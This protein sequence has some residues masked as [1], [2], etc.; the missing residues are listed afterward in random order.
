MRVAGGS[1]IGLF[2]FLLAVGVATGCGVRLGGASAQERQGEPLAWHEVFQKAVTWPETMLLGRARYRQYRAAGPSDKAFAAVD[3]AV[4]RIRMADSTFALYEHR[5][6]R[7]WATLQLPNVPV[8]E[9]RLT[10]PLDWFNSTGT[11]IERGLIRLVL[12]RIEADCAVAALATAP[13]RA[14]LSALERE[15]VDADDPRWLEL[16]CTTTDWEDETAPLR[17][18]DTFGRSAGM[19]EQ[20]FR[21]ECAFSPDELQKQQ[22][23]LDA[24]WT[25]LFQDA[26]GVRSQVAKLAAEYAALRDRVRFG[27]RP[28]KNALA[29]TALPDMKTEWEEQLAN[30][31]AELRRRDWYRKPAVERQSLRRAALILDSDRDPTD[32]VLRRTRALLDHLRLTCGSEVGGLE[33]HDTRLCRLEQV[34][35]TIPVRLR[36]ARHALLFEVCRLRRC[37]A[38]SNPLL[39][40]DKVLVVKRQVSAEDIMAERSAAITSPFNPVGKR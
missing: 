22:E 26:E 27:L 23:Q 9:S 30:L 24:R 3:L 20:A 2:R 13:L 5:V 33:S 29:D 35:A 6:T 1:A 17:G 39:D 36:D 28:V 34:A 38:F 12:E 31:D 37:I 14:R 21:E 32:V 10:T 16:Y 18:L 25:R 7:D 4:R 15:N 19:I 8:G 11:E 40:F